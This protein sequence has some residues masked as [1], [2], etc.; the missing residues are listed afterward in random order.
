V[1]DTHCHL[2][3]DELVGELPAVIERARAAGVVGMIAPGV[4]PASWAGLAA[5]GARHAGDGVAIA[6]G[7]HPQCVAELDAGERARL[8]DVPA[9]IAEAVAAA[10]AAGATVC[11]VGECGLDGAH[12]ARAAQ[13]ALLRGHVRAARA[14]GLPLILHAVR[15]HD[16][17]PGILRDEGAG[18]VGG[19][20]HSYGG[21]PELIATYAAFGLAFAF[22]GPVTWPGARRPLAA[23]RAVPAELLLAETDAPDQAPASRRGRPSEPA[24]VAE[25]IAGLA[26]AR[27]AAPAEVAALTM[28]NAQRVFGLLGSSPP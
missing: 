7:V 2:D 1:I 11:A 5:I 19:V 16:V 28:A 10:R 20:M 9:A 22:A 26:A 24:L 3:R 13:E 18:E 23:A 4:R 15:C 25:V 8:E 27:G 6:I 21:P 17:L 14:L 12:G